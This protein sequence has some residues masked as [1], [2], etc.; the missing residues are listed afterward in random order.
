M[1]CLNSEIQRPRESCAAGGVIDGLRAA[2]V[3]DEAQE[4]FLG[5]SFLRVFGSVAGDRR[6][7]DT[8]ARAL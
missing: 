5:G 4:R 8:A 6:V 3:S 1:N 7:P 2:G